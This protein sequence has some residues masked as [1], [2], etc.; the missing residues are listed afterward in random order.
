MSRILLAVF[1]PMLLFSVLHIHTEGSEVSDACSECIHHARHSH[2]SSAD[3][4]IDH[5]VLCQFL[6][7]P[8]IAAGLMTL[9]SPLVVRCQGWQGIS[10]HLPASVAGCI[11]LRAPPCTCLN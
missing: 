4:C 7:L 1:V 8:F 6:T 3:F 10:L 2:L 9:G 11:H 5:C